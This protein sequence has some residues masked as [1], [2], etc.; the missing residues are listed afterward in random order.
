MTT[1]FSLFRHFRKTRNG[2]ERASEECTKLIGKGKLG[3]ILLPVCCAHVQCS[4]MH[5]SV[6]NIHKVATLNKSDSI[7][8]RLFAVLVFFLGTAEYN[9][10]F[11]GFYACIRI[12]L[13][14]SLFRHSIFLPPACPLPQFIVRI[15]A[16]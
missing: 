4:F 7:R 15:S 11:H 5:I 13:I 16:D 12:Q 1:F 8:R 14:R 10:V 2:D 9:I 3:S 6:C